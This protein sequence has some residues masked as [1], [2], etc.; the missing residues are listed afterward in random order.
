MAKLIY[1][2]PMFLLEHIRNS[3]HKYLYRK[4]HHNISNS[5]DTTNYNISLL[6]HY[7]G[8]IYILLLLNILHIKR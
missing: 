5:V 1:M 3:F 2:H 4:I 6:I 8:S 7:N